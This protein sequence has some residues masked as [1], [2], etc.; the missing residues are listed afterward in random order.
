MAQLSVETQGIYW[1]IPTY[2]STVKGLKAL[3]FG[4][5]GISGNYMVRA[6]SRSPERWSQ[7][8]ALSRRPPSA[9][10]R[11]SEN[12]R[13]VQADLLQEPKDLA[14]ILKNEHIQASVVNLQ[15]KADGSASNREQRRCVLFRIYATDPKRRGLVMVQRRRT[16]QSQWS[17]YT[18]H[19]MDNETSSLRRANSLQV[20]YFKIVS[21]LL[22]WHLFDQNDSC[23]KLVQNT[24]VVALLCL[25]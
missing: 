8:V 14:Q 18:V 23:F 2:P 3:V 22:T 17:V 6:L 19:R 7:V 10:Q 24:T 11:S 25:Q 21:R 9:S 20:N 4:A 13:H 5:N 16:L 15:K 12:V 1:G